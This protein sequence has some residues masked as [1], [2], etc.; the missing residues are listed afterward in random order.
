MK[1]LVKGVV[2]GV[3]GTGV[4]TALPVAV[5]KARAS[6][7]RRRPE[8]WADAPTPAQVAKKAVDALGQGKRSDREDVPLM[9]K[10]MHW[11]YGVTWGAP[12]T[13]SPR[14]RGGRIR[15]AGGLAFGTGRVGSELRRSSCRSGI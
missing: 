11:L 4:L 9:T 7:S 1:S 15:S 10:A 13:A 12:A 2:A 6:P 5:A 8:H 3:A 14:A